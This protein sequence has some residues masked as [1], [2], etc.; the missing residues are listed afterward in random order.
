MDSF[1]SNADMLQ[2]WCNL[3]VQG[4]DSLSPKEVA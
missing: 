1:G 2:L 4:V 3:H